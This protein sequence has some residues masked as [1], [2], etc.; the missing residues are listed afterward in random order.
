MKS[1]ETPNIRNIAIGG[2]SGEG[3]T[4]LVEAILWSQKQI[5]RLGNVVDGNTV[6]DY[7]P[8]EV[9]RQHSINASLLPVEAKGV[10]LNLLDLPGRMDFIGEIRNCL[11]V[12]DATLLVGDASAKVGVGSEFVWEYLD[13]FEVKPRFF[14]VNKMDKDQAN[15]EATLSAIHETFGIRTVALSLPV[16]VGADFKGVIDLVKMKFVQEE[17]QKVSYADIPEDLVSAAET[18]RATMVEAAAEGDDDLMMKFLEDEELTDEEILKGLKGAMGEGRVLP[19]LCGSSAAVKGIDPLMNLLRDCAPNPSEG[20]GLQTTQG[21][22]GPSETLRV[23]TEGPTRAFIFKTVSDPYAGHLSFFKVMRGTFKGESSIHNLNRSASERVAHI[24]SVSGKKNSH[25]D[26]AAAGD[27]GALGKLDSTQTY[28]TLSAEHGDKTLFTPTPMPKPVIHMAVTAKSKTDED[29]IGIGFHRLVDQDPTLHLYRDPDVHQTILSGMGDAHL[30]VAVHRLK[31]M[32][33]V[34]V[35]LSIPKVPYRET[36]T[37]KAEGQGK[38]KKQSGGR[39]QYGDCWIRFEPLEEKEGFEFD[40]QI[41][42]GVIP[43]KFKPSVEK[44]LIEAIQHGV[45]ANSPT[46]GVRAICYDGS[47]HN[48]DSSEM[49]FKVAASL[50]FKGVL[51]KAGPVVLEPIYKVKVTVPEQ[52]MGDIM[53]DMNS[54][55]GRILNTTAEGKKQV[56]EA[57]APQSEMFTYSR[58]LRSM[59]RGSGVY[60]AEFDRYERVP[61]EIQEKIIAESKKDNGDES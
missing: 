60:E 32:S 50:A 9:R 24:L 29:K 49:A 35:E 17:G 39:G 1:F 22:S 6:S 48:V 30:D 46:V 56:I 58:D 37:K 44:G 18:A 8:E 27:L 54:R 13:E 43:T 3:K 19:V 26:W 14:F 16:G 52:Y 47:F 7:D 11:R 10:K 23:E 25:V 61:G 33:H 36:I 57:Q 28:D 53:G 42:G 38:Y 51:P 21:G 15:F 45:L 5:D 41:V 40:W 34:E 2:H 4:S 31:D 12:C 55:R 20:A 59:T